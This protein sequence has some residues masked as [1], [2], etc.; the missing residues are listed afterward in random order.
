MS[1][2]KFYYFPGR[3]RGEIC[4]LALAAA[5]LEFEDIRLAGE[6]WTKEKASGRPPFGQMP[7]I[8]T[9]EGKVLAQS[10][11]IMKYICKKGGLSP[12]DSY[13]EAMADMICDGVNDLF[14]AL[15]KIYFEKDEKKKEELSKEFFD[16]TLPA[17]LEKFN[18]LL[19][20]PFFIGDKFTYADIM[21]FDL[22]NNAMGRGKQEVP[23]QLS[24]FPKLVEHH[25]KVRN[26]PGIKAWLEKRP[27]SEF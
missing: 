22:F 27:E 20:G 25:K 23:E 3:G 2:Y 18:A 12:S 6:E 8:V 17:R 13:E 26:V 19:K 10:A 7:F 11:A 15:M 1:G 24:K 4:R 14:S 16:T 9:P 21:F 5:N